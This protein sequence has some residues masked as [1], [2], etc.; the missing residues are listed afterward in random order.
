MEIITDVYEVVHYITGMEIMNQTSDIKTR[1]NLIC[2]IDEGTHDERVNQS[3]QRVEEHVRREIVTT[4]DNAMLDGEGC[5]SSI[6]WQDAN[7]K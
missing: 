1:R 2:F 7:K 3:I 4:C 6:G 5:I